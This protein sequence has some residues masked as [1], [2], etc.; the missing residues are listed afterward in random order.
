MRF[1]QYSCLQIRI[2]RPAGHLL[3]IGHY[4]TANHIVNWSSSAPSST[5][6][7]LVA[8]VAVGAVVLVVLVVLVVVVVVVVPPVL[9]AVFVLAASP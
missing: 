1:F 4:N 5:S 3:H 2:V 8:A 6:H 7:G 9:S